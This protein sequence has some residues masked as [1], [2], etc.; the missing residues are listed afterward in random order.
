MEE[1]YIIRVIFDPE[2]EVHDDHVHYHERILTY[3]NKLESLSKAKETVVSLFT[4]KVIEISG[5]ADIVDYKPV[6]KIQRVQI[7]KVKDEEKEI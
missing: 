1:K 2:M 6:S 4:G 7:I 3:D 5:A